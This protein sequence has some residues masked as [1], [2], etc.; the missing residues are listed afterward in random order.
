MDLAEGE[1][2]HPIWREEQWGWNRRLSVEENLR[3]SAGFGWRLNSRKAGPELTVT[4]KSPGTRQ[5][6]SGHVM[7]ECGTGEGRPQEG[8]G[9][10]C[11]ARWVA[12]RSSI[13]TASAPAPRLGK[14]P[15]GILLSAVFLLCTFAVATELSNPNI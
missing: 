2:G 13:R 8:R 4:T 1:T 3:V 9:Q 10:G 5:A 11:N 15:V 12:S 7:T 6:T 14:S